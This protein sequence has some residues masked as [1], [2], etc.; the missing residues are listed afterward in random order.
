LAEYLGQFEAALIANVEDDEQVVFKAVT[1]DMIK[2]KPQF[3]KMHLAAGR[4]MIRTSNYSIL[5]LWSKKMAK[6]R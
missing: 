5:S 3:R 1:T 6:R 4:I 2:A